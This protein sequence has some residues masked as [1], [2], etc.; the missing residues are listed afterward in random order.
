MVGNPRLTGATKV[1]QSTMGLGTRRAQ[2]PLEALTTS[3]VT[4]DKHHVPHPR[5]SVNL[6][7]CPVFWVRMLYA[8]TGPQDM[9]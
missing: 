6:K 4:Y 1:Q 7:V 2:C 5:V 9:R 8:L 3:R